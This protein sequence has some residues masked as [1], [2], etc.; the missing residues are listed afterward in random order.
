MF[1]LIDG[2]NFYVSCER[3]FNPKLAGRPVVVLSNNDGCVISRSNEAKLLGVRM[4][5]PWFECR[6]LV[7]HHGL[8]G[9]SANF[10]LYGDMS[11]RLMTL[12]AQFAPRQEVYSIDECF[13]H[14]EGIKAA[15]LKALCQQLRT[16]VLRCT[17]IP[18]CIGLGP[19]QTLAKLAN[20]IAKTAERQAD[21]YP[22]QYAHHHA[23]VCDLG[24]LSAAERAQLLQTTEVGDVWG[25]GR[26]LAPK[27]Q[28]LGVHTADD[29][30]LAN[31]KIIRKLFGVTLER[32]VLELQG[33][34]CLDLQEMA[35]DKQQIACTRSFGQPVLLE[36]DLSQA[37]STFA[38]RT[39]QKLRQ[40]NQVAA[41]VMIYI[42]TSPFRPDTPQYSQFAQQVTVCEI[43]TGICPNRRRNLWISLLVMIG[44]CPN[45]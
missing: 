27:L 3:A 11:A 30:R 21:P 43:L 31:P 23:Q 44:V 37:L 34:P 22:A 4:A 2:N 1:A 14:F 6:S 42:R 17:G 7:Q 8:M 45:R 19:T 33:T 18:T 24:T 12:A 16:H 29:L 25:I 28:A 13:L 35:P 5:Q 9:L 10:A 40:Q 20:H 15:E 39:A 36:S 38:S 41:A 32:T 26:K